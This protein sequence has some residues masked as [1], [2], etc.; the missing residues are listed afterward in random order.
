[1]EDCKR[2]PLSLFGRKPR[3]VELG[4]GCR[5]INP[6]FDPCVSGTIYYFISLAKHVLQQQL[7]QLRE[8]EKI[9]YTDEKKKTFS[10]FRFQ[11]EKTIPQ[12]M[13][14]KNN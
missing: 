1:M 6:D 5:I 13:N 4:E 12:K 7:Q 2:L 11:Q 10:L 8:R 9:R 14:K 3:P